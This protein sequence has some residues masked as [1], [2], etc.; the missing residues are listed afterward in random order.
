L[1]DWNYQGSFGPGWVPTDWIWECPDLFTIP[2][3]SDPARI[4]WVLHASLIIPD[5]VDPKAPQELGHNKQRYF[6]GAFDGRQFMPF[7]AD[8][9]LG[10]IPTSFG[11]DDYAA[12]TFAN[13]PQGE[14]ILMGWMNHWAYAWPAHHQGKT[15]Q[16][17]LPR[18]LSLHNTPDGLRLFQQPVGAPDPKQAG[19]RRLWEALS[20]D[21]QMVTWPE[22][23]GAAFA[24]T[25]QFKAGPASE[26]GFCLRKSASEETLIGYDV[27]RSVVFVDRTR[28]G[29]ASF[30]PQFA[31]RHT[32]PLALTDGHL[33]L[34]IFVDT[35][36]VELYV[37]D[38]QIVLNYLIFPAPNSQGLAVYATGGQVELETVDYIPLG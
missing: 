18:R 5:P 2:L 16:M 21:Q 6:I 20:L 36:S 32:V 23:T 4:V 8:T 15:G 7:A 38:G 11:A 31:T 29:D 37:N 22:P 9:P 24:I 19:W 30:H 27:S 1:R 25:A 34:Q 35:C 26:F 10:G 33:K 3:D 13:A 17:T 14:R 12:I 28:S